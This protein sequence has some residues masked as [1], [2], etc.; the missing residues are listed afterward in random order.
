[1]SSHEITPRLFLGAVGASLALPDLTA[2]AAQGQGPSSSRSSGTVEK[3]VVYGKGGDTEL[4]C[5]IYKPSVASEKR[6]AIIHFHG[7]GF[8]GGSKDTLADRIDRKSVV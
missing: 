8:A 1:M 4:H 6:M 3:D 7:G 2:L 5:D